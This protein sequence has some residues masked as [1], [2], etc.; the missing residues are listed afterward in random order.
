M[1]DNIK[2]YSLKCANCGANLGIPENVGFFACSYCSATQTVLK[3]GGIVSLQM[4]EDKIERIE[5]R[6]QQ[7][8]GLAEI[9]NLTAKLD[10]LN[11]RKVKLLAYNAKNI[12]NVKLALVILLIGVILLSFV[13]YKTKMSVFSFAVIIVLNALFGLF[14]FN[15]SKAGSQKE[16]D[17]EAILK[18][19][20][21]EIETVRQQISDI[22][23]RSG[24]K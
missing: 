22:K 18:M 17:G 12:E 8:S 3:G 24:L 9:T 1:N 10:A 20:D 4:V 21:D 5:E 2:I 13:V 19:L 16:N 23:A 7:T 11:K 6:L 14:L 15:K